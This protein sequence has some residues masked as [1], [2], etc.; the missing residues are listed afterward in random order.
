MRTVSKRLPTGLGAVLEFSILFFQ[1]DQIHKLV[2][3]EIWYLCVDMLN[4]TV[5]K[6]IP[7]GEIVVYVFTNATHHLH[8]TSV[9]LIPSFA[10]TD[11]SVS[12]YQP[13]PT[14]Q[15]CCGINYYKVAREPGPGPNTEDLE[16]R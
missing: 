2:F 5:N 15:F 16:C 7:G 8:F 13:I 12:K 1:T 14:L 10:N 3:K 9:P 4:N 6:I 11:T